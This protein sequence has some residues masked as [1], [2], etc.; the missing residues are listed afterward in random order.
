MGLV[1]LPSDLDDIDKRAERAAHTEALRL[2]ERR[3]GLQVRVHGKVLALFRFGRVVFAVDAACPHQGVGLCEG[4][5]GDIEDMVLGQ[6]H[7]VRCRAHKFQ[8]DLATGEVLEGS[9]SPL[10]TYKTKVSQSSDAVAHVQVGFSS[11][12]ADYF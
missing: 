4:E 7:Y 3:A 11:L 8:F 2:M 12:G 9:C 6:R 5:V 10:Q 1:R